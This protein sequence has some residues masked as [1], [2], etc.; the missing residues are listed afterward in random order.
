VIEK[1]ETRSPRKRIMALAIAFCAPIVMTGCASEQVPEKSWKDY[2]GDG[3][4]LAIQENREEA[5]AQFQLALDKLKG[6]EF[7][8][9]WRPEIL[10]RMARIE[11][12]DGHLDEADKLTKE[13]VKLSIDKKWQGPNH[14]EVLVAIDDLSEAYGERALKDRVNKIRCLETSI[15]LLEPPIATKRG[16]AYRRCAKELAVEYII[17]GQDEKAQP[18]IPDA[19]AD[20]KGKDLKAFTSVRD[21]A[22]A[23][24][25]AGKKARFQEYF[26]MGIGMISK[27]EPEQWM[28]QTV[29]YHA[30]KMYRDR[31]RY[32]EAEKM[33]LD[34]LDTMK[35]RSPHPEIL[36]CLATIYEGK[37]DIKKAD[38]VY[39]KM[40][41]PEN[42]K[43]FTKKEQRQH[44]D[45]Y[46]SYLKRTKRL[47]QSTEIQQQA[48]GLRDSTF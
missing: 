12:I 24:K 39:A 47:D 23:Y 32:D 40:V 2:Y 16:K 33:L 22:C 35:Q 31:K 13:A 38:E 6:V 10:A 42:L 1:N 21:I 48:D 5:L 8:N 15:M 46:A 19:I 45:K 20:D 14:G 25:I 44:L 18:L 3:K 27:K 30:A 4:I 9:D 43:K 28:H 29:S 37:G 11:V 7:E 34:Y 36:E 41:L 26:K 17:S